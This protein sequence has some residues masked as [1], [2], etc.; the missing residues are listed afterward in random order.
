MLGDTETRGKGALG[1]ASMAFD[2]LCEQ[3]KV[4]HIGMNPD[5]VRSK[6]LFAVHNFPGQIR[7]IQNLP[8]PIKII[9]YFRKSNFFLLP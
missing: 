6:N 9:K 7:L 4:I 1:T 8:Y 2:W 5:Q 3:L